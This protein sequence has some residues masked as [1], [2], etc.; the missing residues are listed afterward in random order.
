[1]N[2]TISFRSQLLGELTTFL[3]NEGVESA[4]MTQALLALVAGLAN[5]KEEGVALWPDIYACEDR[6]WLTRE[7]PG[8][9]IISLGTGP[10]GEKT[11]LEALK[12]CGPLA[13]GG[14]AI[15]LLPGE[16][17]CSYGVFRARTTP[18]AATPE[19]MIDEEGTEAPTVIHLK[20]LAESCVEISGS[21]GNCC[22]VYLS[23]T[24]DEV[25]SPKIPTESLARAITKD[26][27]DSERDSV[28][29][30]VYRALAR[31]LADCHGTLAVVLPKRRRVIPKKLSDATLFEQPLSLACLVSE[32]KGQKNDETMARLEAAACLIQGTL[33]SD[34]IVMF[35]SNAT[36][37][38]YR[39]FLSQSSPRAAKARNNTEGGARRRAFNTLQGLLDSGDVNA[40][41]F[42]SQ[43]GETLFKGE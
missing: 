14:W 30:F 28:Y 19:E 40:A 23:A 6:E 34:G 36:L 29:R 3:E 2:K 24:R 20:N 21:R 7:N 22:C 17:G 41:F 43:D 25:P 26:V 12:I 10:I 4:Q 32:Y 1:M 9:D 8:T 11:A 13:T 15:F 39:A 38:G 18:L 33:Q 16:D 31:A 5:Y 37:V 35:R 42:R 27:P